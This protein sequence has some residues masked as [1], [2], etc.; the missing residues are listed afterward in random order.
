MALEVEVQL[1]DAPVE[2]ASKAVAFW[3]LP[4]PVYDCKRDVFVRGSGVEPYSESI[5][6][7]VRLQ[8]KLWRRCLIRQ[9]RVENVE[10]ISLDDLGGRVLWVIVSLVIF[11][12]LKALLHTIEKPWFSLHIKLVNRVYFHLFTELLALCNDYIRK[13]LLIRT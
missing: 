11:V 7:C 3:H 4:F 6:C 9:V 8:V 12:P 5:W 1:Q 2:R 10:F 13:F